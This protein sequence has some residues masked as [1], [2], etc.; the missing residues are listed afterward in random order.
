MNC[1]G[2]RAELSA[3]VDG[4]LT[5]DE[6]KMI[7]S[8][9]A[10]CDDC[11]LYYEQLA[12]LGALVKG[13]ERFGADEKHVMTIINRTARRGAPEAAWFPVT[14]RVA[15]LTAIIINIALFN[16]FRDYR[17][18]APAGPIYQPIRVERVVEMESQ[19]EVEVSFSF[20]AEDTVKGFAAPVVIDFKRVSYPAGL[21]SGEVEGTVVLNIVVDEKGAVGEMRIVQPL[22]PEVDSFVITS[23]GMLRF[24]PAR[25]GT[26]A[27][28]AVVVLHY[29]FKI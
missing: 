18:R 16:L 29:L 21:L 24:R 11:R 25:I 7:E 2:V 6:G 15:L 1:E 26:T 10:V 5:R 22:S 17:F 3:Y 20:P 27:V 14:I 4:E 28:E 9:L 13:V 8:H 19:P 12:R 23:A